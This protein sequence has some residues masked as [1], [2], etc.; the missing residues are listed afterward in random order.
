VFKNPKNAGMVRKVSLQAKSYLFSP[1]EMLKN[2][3]SGVPMSG[4]FQHDGSE[5]GPPD[6]GRTENDNNC[7]LLCTV[8]PLW[9][10]G[11]RHQ[12]I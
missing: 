7:P 6:S 11:S 12:E 5:S 4:D 10:C 2:S 1:Q 9:L 3:G 8:V